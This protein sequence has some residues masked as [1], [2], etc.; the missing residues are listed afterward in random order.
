LIDGYEIVVHAALSQNG[1]SIEAEVFVG[2]RSLT[3][4]VPLSV[5]AEHQAAFDRWAAW[6]QERER[7]APIWRRKLSSAS[8]WAAMAGVAEIVALVRHAASP[9]EAGLVGA[10]IVGSNMGIAEAGIYAARRVA[11]RGWSA[12]R[13]RV[14]NTIIAAICCAAVLA[15]LVVAT[16]ALTMSGSDR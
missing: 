2:G 13:N 5:T 4:G 1:R 10:L 15:V 12:S 7:E 9:G 14:A 8:R 6:Q 16:V 11:A 3:T